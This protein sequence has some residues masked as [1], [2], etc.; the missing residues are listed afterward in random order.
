[1]FIV[2]ISCVQ[3]YRYWVWFTLQLTVSQPVRPSVRP[4]VLA[5]RPSGTHDQILAAVRQLRDGVMGC[6]PWQLVGC[7]LRV[8]VICK[9]KGV[10]KSFR[11]GRLERQLQTVQFSA[12]RCS[13]IAI[14]WASLVSFGAITLCVV[15]QRVFIIVVLVV[16]L[17]TLSGNFWIHPRI[18]SF[19]VTVFFS[20]LFILTRRRGHRDP[21]GDPPGRAA[22]QH[23]RIAVVLPA[24]IIYHPR[25]FSWCFMCQNVRGC[26]QKF[27]DWVDNAINN[28]NN[29]KHS[30]RSNTKGYGGKTH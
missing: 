8:T 21:E 16:Y 22:P 6:L 28:N 14:L 2:L 9:Y 29:N 13:C 4:S 20:W 5:L 1:M 18:Y 23:R 25:Y 17:S 26:I 10:S 12:T 24:I 3:L 11:T 7:H 27:P 15:S 30:L 19:S